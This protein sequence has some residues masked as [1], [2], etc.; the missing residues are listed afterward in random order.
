MY[1]GAK[2]RQ[3]CNN[4]WNHKTR[5]SILIWSDNT[6]FRIS[7]ALPGGS[8]GDEEEF[9]ALLH[10]PPVPGQEGHRQQVLCTKQGLPSG[11]L[12]LSQPEDPQLTPES[13]ALRSSPQHFSLKT[14]PIR[15]TG[16]PEEENYVN[17]ILNLWLPTW[18]LLSTYFAA[19][20]SHISTLFH[21]S[22]SNSGQ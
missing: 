10:A 1:L 6:A 20:S 11:K 14:E 17:I 19:S 3:R 12:L 7:E 15:E 8:A 9:R 22:Q 16:T 18:H 5:I 4:W 13:F 21:S 2:N